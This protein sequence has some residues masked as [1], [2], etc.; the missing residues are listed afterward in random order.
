MYL[1]IKA[2]DGNYYVVKKSDIRR[3]Y[4]DFKGKTCICFNGT[5][6]TPIYVN[7]SI[8]DFFNIHLAK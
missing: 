4:S 7:E 1:L 5:K 3:I 2:E 6:N 8:E